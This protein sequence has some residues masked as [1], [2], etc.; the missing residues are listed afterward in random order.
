MSYTSADPTFI[1]A[2]GADVGM[3]APREIERELAPSP[4]EL[5]PFER[6][7]SPV[8]PWFYH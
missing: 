5:V 4:D 8:L 7:A 1:E 3:I 2:V 6:A